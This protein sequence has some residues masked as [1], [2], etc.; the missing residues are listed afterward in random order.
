L[1]NRE[2]QFAR[3]RQSGRAPPALM[4]GFCVVLGILV[5]LF[6]PAPR[7]RVERQ[8]LRQYDAV[9]R[10]N[11]KLQDFP[12]GC[13]IFRRKSAGGSRAGCT[14]RSG[15]TLTALRIEISNALGKA[16]AP[17]VR[18][19]LERARGLAERCVQTIRDIALVLRPALLD[20]RVCLPRCSG[21]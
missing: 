17:K 11:T 2:M 3:S 20:D 10:P 15:Q 18:E 6:Q 16:A 8:T 4:L 9:A 1:Q 5:A 19:R 12:R 21:R 13:W 14:T 7:P